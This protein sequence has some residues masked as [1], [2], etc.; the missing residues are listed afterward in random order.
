MPAGIIRKLALRVI[1]EE[2]RVPDLGQV[3]PLAAA[4]GNG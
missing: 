3:A 1:G 4:L 2:E